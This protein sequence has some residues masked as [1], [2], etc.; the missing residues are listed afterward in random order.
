MV[1]SPRVDRA[2]LAPTFVDLPTVTTYHSCARWTPS[3]PKLLRTPPSYSPGRSTLRFLLFGLLH[4]IGK[5]WPDASPSLLD[6]DGVLGACDRRRHAA[7]RTD[8]HR[9]HQPLCQGNSDSPRPGLLRAHSDHFRR[10]PC[11][12]RQSGPQHGLGSPRAKGRQ[13]EGG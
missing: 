11:L 3:P 8:R 5:E 13:P 12:G 2:F 4:W 6:R 1:N 9:A 7:R 10:P